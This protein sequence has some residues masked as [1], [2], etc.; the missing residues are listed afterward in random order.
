MNENYKIDKF[1]LVEQQEQRAVDKA[2]EIEERCNQA[3]VAFLKANYGFVKI[4]NRKAEPELRFLIGAAMVKAA[5]LSGISRVIDPANKFDVTN[6]ILSAYSDLTL[7]EIYK[8]FELERYGVYEARTE[9]FQLF[10][11]QYV[12]DIMKK[13]RK[14]K[15]DTK[16]QHNISPPQS[17]P[18]ISESQKQEI[19]TKGIIRV[20]DEFKDTGVMPEPNNYIFDALFELKIIPPGD[21]PQMQA[22]YQRK[23]NQ[24]I[25]ELNKEFKVSA[26]QALTLLRFYG[27]EWRCGSAAAFRIVL[28][29]S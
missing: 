27:T 8:A 18:E 25:E 28:W 23:Y 13:Y 29:A 14:W 15:T 9:H 5:V 22:F 6:S 12:T 26:S 1:S 17:L 16:H 7:E 4:R 19:V 24:A 2:A 21:T 3:P 11:A 20:F 10:N